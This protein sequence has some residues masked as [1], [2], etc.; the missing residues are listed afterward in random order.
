MKV[1]VRPAALALFLASAVGAQIPSGLD[2]Q[3]LKQA[4]ANRAGS[5]ATPDA[6]PSSAPGIAQPPSPSPTR[7]AATLTAD[8]RLAQDIRAKKAREKGPAR[9][10]S[11]LFTV[12]QRGSFATDGGISDD[13]VLGTGDQLAVNVFGSATF[14]L[15]AQVDGRGQIII[16]KVGTVRVGGLTLGQARQAV[17][18]RVSQDFSRTTVN[19]QVTRMREI[20]VFVQG[21]VYEPGAYLVPS[22][23][24]LI[25]VLSLAGGPTALGSYRDIRVMRG[26]KEVFHFDLYPYRAEGLGNPNV[27][28][29]SGDTLFVPLVENQVMLKGAFQRVV[30]QADLQPSSGMQTPA[31]EPRDPVQEQ[32]DIL[33]AQRK[34]LLAIVN[35]P[36]HPEVGGPGGQ[37]SAAPSAPSVQLPAFLAGTKAQP[38]ATSASTAVPGASPV[39]PGLPPVLSP[40]VLAAVQA[41]LD[42][43][44]AQI[45]PL[46]AVKGGDHRLKLDPSTNLPYRQPDD[47]L[48][49]WMRRWYDSGV[50]PEMAFE[51]RPGETV[52]DALRY[53]GGLALEAGPGALTLERRTLSGVVTGEEVRPAQAA[54]VSL[55]RGD[56]LSALPQRT[57]TGA[58]VQVSGWVRVPGFFARTSNMKVGDLL[59]QEHEILPD[60]YQPRGEIVRT[61]PDG[62]TRYFA[63]D[64]TKAL[65]GDPAS[66][67]LL[68]DRDKVEL[69][70]VEDFRLPETV[71]VTGPVTR[72]GV[73][74]YHEG[75][76][77]SDLIFR[78]GI[79][80][81]SANELVAE[82]AHSRAGKPSQVLRLDLP[83]LLSTRTESPVGLDDDTLNPRLQPDDQLSFFKLPDAK[84]HR[85]V[86][87]EGQVA[88]PGAYVLESDKETL[89]HLIA[90][91]GGLTPNAMPDAGV[92]LRQM[93]MANS[94]LM[95][96]SRE[97][98]ITSQDP[99][100]NGINEIL[101]RLNETKRSPL[102]GALEKNPVLHDLASGSLNRMVVDF[103]AALKGNA[104]ADVE[105]R[106]GDQII[107]PRQMD[108]AYVVGETASPFANYKVAS[109]MKVRDLLKLAGG[110]TRNADRWNIRLLKADGRIVDSWVMRQPVAP[111]DTLLVP[112]RFRRDT[113]WQENLAA[114]TPIAVMLNVLK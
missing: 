85:I 39:S 65:A 100:A 20:R 60:T 13:Y 113:S 54:A 29:Q 5:A 46:E 68:A 28:L 57:L 106:D 21:E 26:G 14:D 7:E 83:R 82:L 45:K 80:L 87:L 33:L 19:L 101:A 48:P 22:L 34:A 93:C 58:V 59:R 105:L 97:S 42:N 36:P 52:A 24:S 72:P 102:S 44:D 43:L 56:V 61:L 30:G 71:T 55:Q 35:P 90:R 103:P 31:G 110:T 37:G 63:F 112:Q 75:M 8:E 32:L 18:A 94:S 107:I 111:G 23:S 15:P 6:T 67:L 16:P 1:V 99:T 88:Q 41:Q 66:D 12:R 64:V 10:A 17:Q 62:S 53:A 25:N 73:Y 81:K 77:A 4:L 91:A 95:E 49:A 108:S 96:A 74:A 38:E 69:Y 47:S 92:F 51:M 89:S 70:R 84:I 98:G 79:P 86:H 50:A 9:F 11:D 3:A 104:Q 109:G 76:R 78:A 27:T 2:V 40:E 114:L